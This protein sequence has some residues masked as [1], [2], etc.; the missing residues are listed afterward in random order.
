MRNCLVIYEY[1][2]LMLG[3]TRADVVVLVILVVILVFYLKKASGEVTYVV[4]A[5]DGRRYLC[6]KLPDR[7]E[8]AER[9]AGLTERMLSLVHHMVAISPD[10][11]AVQQ[12]YRNFDPDAI[13]EGSHTSGYT[14]F[15]VSKGESITLCI[16]QTDYSFVDPNTVTYVAIHELGHLMTASIGHDETFWSNFKKL[17]EE[18]MKIGVYEKKDFTSSPEAYCGIKITSSIV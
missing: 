18:A 6:L 8:A 17:L 1:V 7:Q 10:D 12:L 15:S 3:V 9:L 5:L 13:H 16:R 2:D 4:A 14:S 11:E